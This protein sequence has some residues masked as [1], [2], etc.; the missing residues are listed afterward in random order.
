MLFRS[1]SPSP[2]PSPPPAASASTLRPFRNA[3]TNQ[4]F[5]LL[6]DALDAASSGDTIKVAAGNYVITSIN[7]IGALWSQYG[8]QQNTLTIE[9]ET[10]GSMAVFDISAW[11]QA[12]NQQGGDSPGLMMG[13]AC[14]NLT[15]RG[16]GIRGYRA[17]GAKIGR[18][19]V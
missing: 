17:S 18:A 15:V 16:I 8:V 7:D 9:W 11:A 2:S 19:H 6:R 10:P 12:N 4:Q 3:R 13:S 14:R 5:A 1:P